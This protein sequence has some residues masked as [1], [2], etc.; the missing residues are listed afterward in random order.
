MEEATYT[1]RLDSAG[2]HYVDGPGP[3]GECSYYGAL[4]YSHTRFENEEDA[5]RAAIIANIAYREGYEKAQYDIRNAL[6]MGEP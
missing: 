5:E 6:G 1:A 2:R 4:L 3:A